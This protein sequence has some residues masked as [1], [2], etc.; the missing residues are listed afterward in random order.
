MLVSG[1]GTLLQALLDEVATGALPID[2][3]AVGSDRPDAYGLVRAQLAGVDTF[4]RPLRK[5][6][7]RARWDEDLTADVAAHD[8]A[9]VVLAGFMRLVGSAFLDRFGGRTINS[10]P[11]LLPAFPG[12]H[13]VRDA[14]AYGVKVTGCTIIAVD[15]GVDTGRILAQEAVSVLPGDTEESLHERIKHVERRMLVDVVRTILKENP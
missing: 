1:S 5:G 14:L 2:I 11:A 9:L 6:M 3:A 12:A 7:D 15:P 4:V 13:G 10:H 8:P